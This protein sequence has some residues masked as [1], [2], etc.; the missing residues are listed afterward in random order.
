MGLKSSARH[1]RTS[2]RRNQGRRFFTCVRYEEQGLEAPPGKPRRRLG[3][4]ERPGVKAQAHKLG[5]PTRD[6]EDRS[7]AFIEKA[8]PAPEQS[9]PAE[10]H[11]S[12]DVFFAGAVMGMMDRDGEAAFAWALRH[13]SKRSRP[14]ASSLLL[15]T[16]L[17]RRKRKKPTWGNI[18][19]CP[20]TSAYSLTNLPAGPG[21]PSPS[22][23]FHVRV[24]PLRSPA[25]VAKSGGF[26]TAPLTIA[27]T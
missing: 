22:L 20:P 8:V 24:L 21:C 13:V 26:L 10:V 27:M 5:L 3:G 11:Q 15:A 14:P 2:G 17:C 19:R 18:L 23:D 25:N 4:G 12:G 16:C 7:H 9:E 1:E 6:A